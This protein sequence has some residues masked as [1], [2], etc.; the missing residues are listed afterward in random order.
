MSLIIAHRAYSDHTLLTQNVGVRLGNFP[1]LFGER[2]VPS[3][4]PNDLE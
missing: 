2:L 3:H 1:Y 4:D